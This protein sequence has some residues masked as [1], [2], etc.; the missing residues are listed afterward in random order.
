MYFVV[1]GGIF[2]AVNKAYGGAWIPFVPVSIF[3]E[4][5][6]V[7]TFLPSNPVVIVPSPYCT[8]HLRRKLPDPHYDDP[9]K[10]KFDVKMI[11]ENHRLI[12]KS[13]NTYEVKF[14]LLYR[15]FLEVRF[16]STKTCNHSKSHILIMHVVRK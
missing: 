10:T 11:E 2:Y 9:I 16:H 6:L 15:S 8:V 12:Q 3:G 7:K 5:Y 1:D 14:Y 4:Y 13:K